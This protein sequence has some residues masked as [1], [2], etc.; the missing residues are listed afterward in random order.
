MNSNRIHHMSLAPLA[1]QVGIVKKTGK[2][3]SPI[4]GND[5][6]A[7]YLLM[8]VRA[9]IQTHSLQALHAIGWH[10]HM[11]PLPRP[12]ANWAQAQRQAFAATETLNLKR[13][14][15]HWP[16]LV[17]RYLVAEM[18]HHGI[19]SLR[20]TKDKDSIELQEAIKP[21]QVGRGLVAEV[22][23]AYSLPGAR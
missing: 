8:P 9:A 11:L 10:L 1:L 14:Q 3:G 12:N 21:A 13:W 23:G 2:R 20:V 18:R 19:M 17:R 4:G 6:G 16:W 5:V 15:C 7:I 22:V